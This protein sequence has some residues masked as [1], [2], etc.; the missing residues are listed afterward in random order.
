MS[1]ESS[2]VSKPDLT[3]FDI[4]QGAPAG[5]PSC[6]SCSKEIR[7]VYHEAN[8]AVICSPCRANLQ[9]GRAGGSGID[10]FG[11][12]LGFGLVGAAIGSVLWFAVLA[13]FDMELGLLA[14]VVGF[15]VGK[16]VHMGSHGRGGWKYQTLAVVLTYSAIVVTYIPFIVKG[17]REGG[18]DP[19]QFADSMAVA[20]T[21][22]GDA[23]VDGVMTPLVEASLPEGLDTAT[24]DVAVQEIV[25]GSEPSAA[26]MLGAGL[27]VLIALFAMAAA[28]PI[29]AGL[30][31]IIGLLIIAFALYQ[32]WGMNKRVEL[33]LTGPYRVGVPRDAEGPAAA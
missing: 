6:T 14:I 26:F 22:A 11:R 7:D 13:L 29:L 5:P 31:N 25:E 27:V 32:A 18:F 17:M 10:R 20:G 24:S 16:G 3:T 9:L 8:G 19:A 28:A 2:P 23:V 4:A 12:S 1:T 21:P 30:D 15:L 33:T